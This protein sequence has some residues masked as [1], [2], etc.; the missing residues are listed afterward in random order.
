MRV[1]YTADPVAKCFVH[2]IFQ[3]SAAMC[4]TANFRASQFHSNDIQ[5]LSLN[6]RFSHKYHTFATEQCTDCSCGH[7]VLSGACLG[8][9]LFLAHSPCQQRLPECIVDFMC[10]GMI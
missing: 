4:H 5:L 10:A 2:C 6:I 3:C 7:A 9:D 1:I 8:N